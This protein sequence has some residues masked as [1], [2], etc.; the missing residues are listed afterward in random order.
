MLLFALLYFDII[1]VLFCI[2]WNLG[3]A[4]DNDG[5]ASNAGGGKKNSSAQHSSSK[6]RSEPI[7]DIDEADDSDSSDDEA[8]KK[9]ELRRGFKDKFEKGNGGG[10][11]SRAKRGGGSHGAKKASKADDKK[12]WGY[13]SSGAKSGQ[14]GA[15]E[16]KGTFTRRVMVL[17]KSMKSITGKSS[18]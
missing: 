3:D 15:S 11:T 9:L 1:N 14:Q 17:P 18:K 4:E 2:R 7:N 6:R 12:S 8:R 5:P 16:E 10:D 13:K